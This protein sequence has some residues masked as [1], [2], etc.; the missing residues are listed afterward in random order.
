MAAME[1][2][3]FSAMIINAHLSSIVAVSLSKTQF[4]MDGFPMIS[5]FAMIFQDLPMN[6]PFQCPFHSGDLSLNRRV[7]DDICP[8]GKR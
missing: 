7:T 6:F 4:I 8:M 1:P 5:H 3:P 2:L